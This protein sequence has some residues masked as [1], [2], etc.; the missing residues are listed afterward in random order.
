M[1][2]RDA[3][4]LTAD[5]LGMPNGHSL[6][7]SL[8]DDLPNNCSCSWAASWLDVAA[9][10]SRE[11]L[12]TGESVSGQSGVVVHFKA[13]VCGGF[14]VRACASTHT[15]LCIPQYNLICQMTAALPSVLK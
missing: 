4:L 7:H 5:L 13:V 14:S 3:S 9:Q 12:I 6:V 1:S 8:T 11:K 2:F 10:S 15:Y